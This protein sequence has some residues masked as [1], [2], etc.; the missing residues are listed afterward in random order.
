MAE[1]LKNRYNRTFF[2]SLLRDFEASGYSL[3]AKSFYARLF[4]PEW[5]AMELKERLRHITEVLHE[6]ID[7]PFAEAL[8][9][10]KPVAAL[11]EPTFEHMFFPDYVELYGL[12]EDWDT[13]MAGL[14]HFTKYS[15]SE[16][17]IRPFIL[18]DAKRAMTQMAAWASHE[19]YHVRRLASEGCRP[20]L[21][22]AMALPDFKRDPSPILPILGT[23]K[24]DPT[25]YVRRSVANNLN[26]IAKDHPEIVLK[27]AKE[28][29][30]QSKETDWIVKHACRTLLKQG[31]PKALRLFGFGDPALVQVS[32]LRTTLSHVAIGD[33]LHFSFAFQHEAKAS[34]KLRVEYGIYYLKA[35][36]KQNRKVFMITENEYEPNKVYTFERKQSF[37]NM[38]TRKH[39]V[40]PHRLSIIVNGEE[41]EEIEFEVR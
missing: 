9:I 17:A 4:T 6:V 1:P 23:L 41:Q 7:Q 40:G 2:D 34:L 30:G 11:Q 14:E 26:D 18:R 24:N 19:N 10:L 20:R 25:D 15:S 29:L 16:F 3:D 28:W 36:G 37:R 5:E 33:D 21:P 22:W 8:E 38:T 13:A 32:G 27:I 35:N 12:E 31:N 39:Y